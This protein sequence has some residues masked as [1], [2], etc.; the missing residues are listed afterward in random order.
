MNRL[1]DLIFS[2]DIGLQ[3]FVAYQKG[4]TFVRIE[5]IKRL[6][7]LAHVSLSLLADAAYAN[8]P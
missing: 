6:D 4:T 2:I 1:L 8:L 7:P 3:F 5:R